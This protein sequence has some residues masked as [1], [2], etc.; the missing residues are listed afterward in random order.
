M[1]KEMVTMVSPSG[2]RRTVEAD[3]AVL[4]PLMVQGW[5]QAPAEETQEAK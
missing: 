3:S 1:E 5:R 4:V 2:E